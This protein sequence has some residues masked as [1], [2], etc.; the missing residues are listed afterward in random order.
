M[1]R[2]ATAD[3]A[4]TLLSIE[5]RASTVALTHVFGPEIPFPDDDV[6]ARWSLVLQ[7]PDATVLLDQERGEPVG[8]VAFSAGWL[9][10]LGVLPA[11]WG[12]GRAATLHDVAVD[13][14]TR[15]GCTT[16]KLWV[17]M[18]ND[19]A[20]AFYRRRG[21]VDTETLE[22]EVFPPYPIKVMMAR[23]LWEDCAFTSLREDRTA[24]VTPF[25]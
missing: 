5:K 23:R 13:A 16:A 4:G 12:T 21:W 24:R 9:R 17:L 19:R 7:D 1:I 15:Q 3:D 22:D 20:R 2:P 8:Y 25:H 11:W 18:R 10:H 6:L 14:L